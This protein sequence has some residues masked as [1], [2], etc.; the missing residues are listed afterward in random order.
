MKTIPHSGILKVSTQ[1]ESLASTSSSSSRGNNSRVHPGRHNAPANQSKG[2]PRKLISGGDGG[3]ILQRLVT[4]TSATSSPKKSSRRVSHRGGSHSSSAA[5]AITAK[6]TSKNDDVVIKHHVHFTNVTIREYEIQPSDNPSPL[7]PP[8]LE[9][10][11][12]YNILVSS[13][14]IDTFENQRM[15]QRL[16]QYQRRPLSIGYRRLLLSE[17]GFTNEEIEMA[18]VRARELREERERSIER[19]DLD[20]CDRIMEDVGLCWKKVRG[21]YGCRRHDGVVVDGVVVVA[22]AVEEEES[23]KKSD[24]D[25]YH[26][27]VEKR[28]LHPTV[29]VE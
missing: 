24:G 10:G 13:F 29:L 28:I 18:S 7:S 19:M 22:A 25:D 6:P 21:G 11:W 14:S 3:S 20:W 15:H 9:L 12:N 17:F 5:K 26:H 16:S 4:F 27:A 2:G 8:G 1:A 23:G